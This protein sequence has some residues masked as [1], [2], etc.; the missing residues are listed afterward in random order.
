MGSVSQSGNEK[1]CEEIVACPFG[2]PTKPIANEPKKKL[3]NSKWE[4]NMVY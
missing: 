2:D 4:T 3:K 1:I